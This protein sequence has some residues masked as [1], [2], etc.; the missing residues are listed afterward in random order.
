MAARSRKSTVLSR[1]PGGPVEVA[2]LGFVPAVERARILAEVLSGVE[3]GVWDQRMVAWLAG[4][5][6]AT[7][8]V[9]ALW[10]VRA[11]GM[12]PAR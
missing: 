3:L 11:R 5:D 7:V 10:I 9:I 6:A 8:L 1:V 2:P 4:W 12:G